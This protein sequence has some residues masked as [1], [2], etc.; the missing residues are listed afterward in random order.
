MPS[1]SEKAPPAAAPTA[2]APVPAGVTREQWDA[3]QAEMRGRPDGAAQTRRLVAYLA[4]SDALRRFRDSRSAGAS[5]DDLLPLALALDDG[6]PARVRAREVSAAEA[7]QIKS[8]ILDITIAD[9]SQRA[10]LL[11]QW[12]VAEFPASPPDPRQVEFDRLQ[13]PIVAAWSAQPPDAR[14]SAALERDLEAARRQSF[15]SPS[16]PR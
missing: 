1:A 10:G 11:Q 15:S 5:A 12:L 9:K 8:A 4:W 3:L 7:R 6:L 16:S 2:I 13:A 14:N